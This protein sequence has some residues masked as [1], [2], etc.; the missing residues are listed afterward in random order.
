MFCVLQ[1]PVLTDIGLAGGPSKDILSRLERRWPIDAMQRT[2]A[3]NAI[4]NESNAQPFDIQV[5][6]VLIPHGCINA[7]CAY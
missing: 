4:D 1:E 5:L 2:F 3:I 7:V 6:Y